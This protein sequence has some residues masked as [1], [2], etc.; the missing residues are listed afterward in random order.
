VLFGERI[1]R[2]A[3]RRAWRDFG[4]ASESRAATPPRPNDAPAAADTGDGHGAEAPRADLARREN[5]A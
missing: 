4:V 1:D 2:A 5:A 3:I